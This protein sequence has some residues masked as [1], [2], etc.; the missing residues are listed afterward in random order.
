M[1]PTKSIPDPNRF[2]RNESFDN[3]F[4]KGI[5]RKAM[6]LNSPGAVYLWRTKLLR[7]RKEAWLAIFEYLP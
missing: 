7:D 2:K 5:E 1:S 6:A 4:A 3:K